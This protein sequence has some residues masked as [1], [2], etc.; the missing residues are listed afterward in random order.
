LL[1]AVLAVDDT[2]R[3]RVLNDWSASEEL[4]CDVEDVRPFWN[5]LRRLADVAVTSG[6]GVFLWNCV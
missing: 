6:R 5:D 3:D 2:S 4:N 1:H